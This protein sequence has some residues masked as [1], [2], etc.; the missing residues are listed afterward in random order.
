[1]HPSLADRFMEVV[2]SLQ[3]VWQGIPVRTAD[4]TSAFDAPSYA[5]RTLHADVP[6]AREIRTWAGHGSP[7]LSR[8][9]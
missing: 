4:P 7:S 8:D 9:P 6:F 2:P 5:N 1:V 3:A